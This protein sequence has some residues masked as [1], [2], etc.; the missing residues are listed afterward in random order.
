MQSVKG[1]AREGVVVVMPAFATAEQPHDPF[2]V[3]LVVRLKLASAEGVTDRI[4]APGDVIRVSRYAQVS[5]HLNRN[6]G[7][8]RDFP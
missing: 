7:E 6:R 4:D 1:G 2:V 8:H 5:A 3:A